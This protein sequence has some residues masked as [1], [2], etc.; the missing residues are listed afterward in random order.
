MLKT[1]LNEPVLPV[2]IRRVIEPGQVKELREFAE[3]QFKNRPYDKNEDFGEA[4]KKI[5]LHNR[6]ESWDSAGAIDEV[7]KRAREYVKDN[8]Y[9]RGSIETKSFSLIEQ[10]DGGSYFENDY[11]LHRRIGDQDVVYYTAWMD[12]GPKNS[13]TEGKVFYSPASLENEI[14]RGARPG[15]LVVHRNEQ[16]NNFV[17]GV[18]TEGVRYTLLIVIAEVIKDHV[19]IFDMEIEQTIDDGIDF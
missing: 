15:D 13:Y 16:N 9:L 18:V 12:L 6:P 3:Q 7:N 8:F 17:F 10:K 11:P 2:V 5:N 1:E 4:T 14:P 19:N